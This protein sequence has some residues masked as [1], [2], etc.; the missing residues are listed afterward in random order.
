MRRSEHLLNNYRYYMVKK[1]LDF[2]AS[3]RELEELSAWFERGEPDLDVGMEKFARAQELVKVLQERLQEAEQTIQ[4]IRVTSER[5]PS[6]VS[7]D[8]D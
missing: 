5:R 2:A 3:Y 1:K 7:S 8:E 4:Q 6:V